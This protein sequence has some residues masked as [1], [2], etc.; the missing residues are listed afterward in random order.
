MDTIKAIAYTE[1]GGPKV[2]HVK[3][4]AEPVIKD[5]EL[6]VRIHAV[7]VNYGDVAARD[8][9]HVTPKK[10]NM[11]LIFWILAKF[12]FGL[13]K[14]KREIL[15]NIYS[16]TI[17][18]AGD[19]VDKFKPG[20]LVFGYLGQ[21]MGAYAQKVAVSEDDIVALKPANMTFEQASIVPYGALMALLL[22]KKTG[23]APGQKIL[24]L[25]ASGGIGSAAVQLAANHFEAEVTGVCGTSNVE[26]VRSLGAREVIDY[27]MEDYTRSGKS[28]NVILDIL[29]RGSFRISRKVLTKNGIYLSASFKFRKLLQMITTS[30]AG[31]KRLKC[32]IVTPV[33]EDLKFIKELVEDG[34]IKPVSFTNFDFTEAPEAHEYL[35]SDQRKGAVVIT[36]P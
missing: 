15:G 20:D 31:G 1:Y 16:G 33:Q 13:G 4:L 29:G 27:K 12:D 36:F 18:Q 11:P 9:K 32:A 7:S 22:L 28:F 3:E 19:K 35:E 30:I 24:I 21:K 8:F 23:I 17:E 26:F 25:G 6:L 14:P 10:F 2:L 34:T 5:N